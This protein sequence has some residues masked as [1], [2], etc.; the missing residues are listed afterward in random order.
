MK[1]LSLWF[2]PAIFALLWVVLTAFTLAELTTV[3]PLLSGERPQLRQGRHA[4][5]M[6]SARR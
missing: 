2:R 1:T 3:A 4:V 5:H 6:S